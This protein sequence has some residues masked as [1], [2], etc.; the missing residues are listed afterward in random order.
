M[1]NLCFTYTALGVFLGMRGRGPARLVFRRAV[2]AAGK[3]K[4]VVSIVSV[5]GQGDAITGMFIV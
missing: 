3:R 5:H 1:V 4:S 2:R